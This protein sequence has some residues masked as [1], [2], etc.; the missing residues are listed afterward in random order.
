[1]TR[2]DPDEAAAA[3][4]ELQ[5][6]QGQAGRGARMPRWLWIVVAVLF[7]AALAQR[8]FLPRDVSSWVGLA[9]VAVLL[10]LSLT[11]YS[12]RGS[13]LLGQA[14][15]PSRALVPVRRRLQI[16]GGM[17]VLIIGFVLL[18]R[19]DLPYVSTAVGVV[20]AVLIVAFGPRFRDWTL[21]VRGG[22]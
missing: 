10:L 19:L 15:Q 14:V 18:T 17:L 9:L 7:A 6:R 21:G 3:M 2:P 11:S 1:M 8:D 16:M 12:R 4:R 22:P 5:R 13:S 20:G